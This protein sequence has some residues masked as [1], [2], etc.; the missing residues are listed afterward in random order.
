M[1]HSGS[2]GQDAHA[3]LGRIPD[4]SILPALD[5]LVRFQGPHSTCNWVIP[6]SL[7]AGSYPGERNEPGHSEKIRATLGAGVTCIVCLMPY[8]EL[9]RFTP[10]LPLVRELQPRVE[11]LHCPIPD[12]SVTND[13]NARTAAETIITRL[14]AG[15]CVYVHCWGGHGRTGTILSVVVARLYAIDPKLAIKFFQTTHAQRCPRRGNFPHGPA[16][17]NQVLLL[18]AEVSG[19][20]LGANQELPVL[21]IL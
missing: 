13:E 12:T 16:Q 1:V 21:D 7:L 20:G 14:K 9:S 3:I 8:D 18:G 5:D 19:T 6:G 11:V 4:L 17:E 10:Y 2:G 15:G